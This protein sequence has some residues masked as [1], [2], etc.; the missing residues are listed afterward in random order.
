VS[1]F[2]GSPETRALDDVGFFGDDVTL[3]GGMKGALRLIPVYAATSLIADSLSTLPFHAFQD[4]ADGGRMKLATQPRLVAA[5]QVTGGR[6]AW[7]HQ[8]VVSMLLRGNAYGY[9]TRFDSLAYAEQVVWLHP[10]RVSVD[11]TKSLPAYRYKGQLLDPA[12]VVHIPAFT[13]PGSCVGLSPIALFAEQ[14]LKSV[15]A[16][17]FASDFLR[18]GVAPPGILRNKAKVLEAGDTAIAKRRFKEAVAGRDIFVTGNDWEWESLTVSAGEAMFLEAIEAGATEIAA[19]FRVAP[20]DIGGKTGHSRQYSTLVMEMQK[21]SSRTLLPWTARL[22]EAI[23]E[24]MRPGTYARFNLDA[25]ARADLKTRMETHEIALR[26][27]METLDEG[28]ALEEK[29][30]LTADQL[31]QWQ[32]FHGRQLQQAPA[33]SPQERSQP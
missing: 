29:P 20:E 22:E 26:T 28:R 24:R 7:V 10:D 12:R 6:I 17:R 14:F 1:L 4:T 2:F 23:S 31:A 19:I 27:G 13:V 33:P 18:R 16:Q 5:P 30:P 15:R 11:E 25:I 32:S 21:F 8:A 3:G 9:I